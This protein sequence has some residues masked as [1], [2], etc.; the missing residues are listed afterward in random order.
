MPITCVS[1]NVRFGVGLDGRYD[2]VRIADAV[3]DADIILLQEVS[4]G[5]AANGGADMVAALRALLPDR[6]AA[7]GMATDIDFGSA[8]QDGKAVERRFQFGNMVLS[9]WP[10]LAVRSHLLPRVRRD[11]RLNLQR[12][13]LEALIATSLGPMRFLSVHLD[14][15]DGDERLRQIASLRTIMFDP[16]GPGATGLGEF[17]FPDLP[18]SSGVLAM[19]DFNFFPE[20]PDYATMAGEAEDALADV[21]PPPNVMSFYNPAEVNPLQRLDYGFATLALAKRVIRSWIDEK[22]AGSDHRPLWFEIA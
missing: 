10:L 6:F 15:V 21:S 5:L 7:E 22:V 19:G 11:E 1:Y 12:G 9:R 17:G 8:L 20:W 3:R 4:R 14:H 2:P 18:V 16:E 13:A